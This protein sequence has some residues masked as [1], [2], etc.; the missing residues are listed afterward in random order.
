MTNRGII[1]WAG[2]VTVL[3]VFSRLLG[4]F[5]ETAIA[6]RF[7]ATASTDAYLVAAMLPQILFLAFNDAVKTAF[8]PIYGEYHKREDGNAFAL[9]IYVLFT[10]IL[11]V[12]SLLL[13]VA[14][15]TVVR[16]VAPGFT[17][18]QFELTVRM[19]RILLPGLFFMGL[20]G[21]SSGLLHTKKNFLIPALPA[22]P[23]N[24]IVIL[25]ALL[26]GARFGVMGL[27]WGTIVAFASQF[28]IQLPA[29]ARH[30][31]FKKQRLLWRH[32]GI[33]KMAVLLPPVLLGGAALEV[34]S[35]IDR[36]F[37]SLLPEGSIAALNFS[38]RIY[39][40]PN[41]ILIL[42]LLTVLYPT[43]VE[44]HVEGKMQEFK[45]TLRQGVG[46]VILLVFP[47]MVGLVVLR[48]PVVRLLFE[49]GAFN[50]A[51]TA[52][53][54]FALAFYSLGLVA[55]GIQL[56]INRAFY[57][58]KDT[59]TP[60]YV[61]LVMVGLNIFFN[62]LLI[63]PMAHGGIALGTALSINIG[64]VALAYLLWK[65]IG[66]FGGKQ[67][68]ATFWKCGVSA[69][70]MGLL[71]V[72]GEKYLEGAGFLRQA[73]ELGTLIGLGALVYFLLIYWLRVEEL[74]SVLGFV[75]RRLVR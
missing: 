37:G 42:A 13:I 52:S 2:I 23:S 5:R 18:E 25:A 19:S 38:N 20:S 55:L 27:A 26:G 67:L 73:M 14:A 64:T 62:W 7:G 68:L 70:L 21:L 60:M 43:L 33:K 40:L 71:L 63:K 17:G 6:Y 34:K 45:E 51:A 49:R 31:I 46:L 56:L 61:M 12:F 1:K 9:T 65:K 54:A 44:L 29:V 57:A 72:F 41:G 8:I 11:F 74:R 32:P 36:I 28:L 58:L 48:M 4:F 69:L 10:A 75:R 66:A 24:I 15:P 30:G 50:E 47:M 35:I 53:T 59:L 39:L 22:Y 3:L 16:L